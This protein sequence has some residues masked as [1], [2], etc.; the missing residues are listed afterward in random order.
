MA[1]T[2]AERM[3]RMRA[4]R[5]AQSTVVPFDALLVTCWCEHALVLVAPDD[6]KAGRTDTCGRSHCRRQAI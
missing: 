3:A 6:L 1:Y 4:R 2:A 5:R